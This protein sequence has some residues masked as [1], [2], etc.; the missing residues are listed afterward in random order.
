MTSAKRMSIQPRRNVVVGNSWYSVEGYTNGSPRICITRSKEIPLDARAR[1]SPHYAPV[2]NRMT[3][4][5]EP[6]TDAI[7]AFNERM[8]VTESG[9]FWRPVRKTQEQAGDVMSET[10]LL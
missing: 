9:S 4:H 6:S 2:R 1:R 8:P 7:Q 3:N 10:R 5:A